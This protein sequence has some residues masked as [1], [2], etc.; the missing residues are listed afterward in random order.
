MEIITEYIPVGKF[1]KLFNS[2][3]SEVFTVTNLSTISIILLPDK[4]KS[5]TLKLPS[6]KTFIKNSA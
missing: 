1:D 5:E 3:V 4:S 6:S 2:T